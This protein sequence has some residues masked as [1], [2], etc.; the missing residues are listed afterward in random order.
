MTAYLRF[1]GAVKREPAIQ[2][3]FAG[4]PADLAAMAHEWFEVMRGCGP[5]VRE[6]LH[7]DCPT[8]C[9][10]DAAFGYVNVF[11]AHVNVG[12]FQGASLPDPGSRLQGTGKFMRHV[13]LRPGEDVDASELA[14]LIRAA[15]RDMAVRVRAAQ[16]S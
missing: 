13:K 15:Y 4:K 11:K 9:L 16:R 14:E 3:W 6:L 10:G 7:D 2:A 1:T 8:V 5:D 12:F